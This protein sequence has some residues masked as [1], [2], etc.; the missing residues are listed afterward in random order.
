MQFSSILALLGSAAFAVAGNTITFQSLDEVDRTIYFVAN[1]GLEKLEAVEIPGKA[2]LTVDIPQAWIGNW[3]SISK[4]QENIPGML[5]EVAFN[6][7]NDL[8]YFDVSA[9]V[10]PN[11]H[12]G[13]KK[14][15]PAS[16]KTPISGCDFFPCNEAYYLPDDVQ[17]KVTHETDIVCTLGKNGVTS[18][19]GRDIEE[20]ESVKRDFVLGKH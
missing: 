8:T 16:S 14:M 18:I 4:G 6:G 7:W 19:V 3:Y 5:G 2:N 11:D 1:A 13:V 9:I 15:Y 20:T 12:D 10:N 17:T